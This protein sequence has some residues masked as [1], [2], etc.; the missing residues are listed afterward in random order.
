MVIMFNISPTYNEFMFSH[1]SL[2][3]NAAVK[4]TR[5]NAISRS[6]SIFQPKN[7]DHENTLFEA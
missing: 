4:F 5:I 1:H 6:Q 3:S 7:Y 2:A